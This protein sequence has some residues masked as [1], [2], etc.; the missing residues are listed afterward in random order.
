MSLIVSSQNFSSNSSSQEFSSSSDSPSVVMPS[1]SN[2][3]APGSSSSGAS[4]QTKLLVSSSNP[5][6]GTSAS[7]ASGTIVNFEL[8]DKSGNEIK[9]KNT[10]EPFR[11]VIPTQTPARAFRA[12][13]DPLSFTYFKVQFH[14]YFFNLLKATNSTTIFSFICRQTRVHFTFI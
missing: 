4:I 13:L 11:I 5:L 1:L 14:V 8:S 2:I 10:T 7:Q 12:Q 9:V 3:L 6:Q